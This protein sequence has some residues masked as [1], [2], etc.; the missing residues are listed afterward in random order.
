VTPRARKPAQTQD[1]ADRKELM[2]ALA[3][4]NGFPYDGKTAYA[5]L[6]IVSLIDDLN[7]AIDWLSEAL[8]EHVAAQHRTAATEDN[9]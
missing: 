3:T 7:H 5:K 8:C 1:Q 6:E 4:L 2:G 9:V